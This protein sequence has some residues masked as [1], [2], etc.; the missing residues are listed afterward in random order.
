MGE[1]LSRRIL[2]EMLREEWRLHGHLFGG[3]R[4]LAF[5]F[6]VGLLVAGSVTLLALTGTGLDVVF[7]GLHVLAFLFG[8][9]TGSIG[10]VG[11]DALEDLLEDLTLLVFSARTLPL[12]PRR[13]LGIF[14]VKDV[15]YYAFL[16]LL[17]MSVGVVP[18]LEGPPVADA[19]TVLLLWATLTGMFVLG[20]ATTLAGAGLAGRGVPG[21]AALVV[22]AGAG[23]LAWWWGVDIAA[24]TFYGLFEDPSLARLGLASAVVVALAGL[25]VLAF[26]PGRRSRTR[27]AGPSFRLWRDRVDDPV[28][29]KTLLDLSRSSG[30][31]G[32]VLLSG[33]ILFA[34]TAALVDLARSITGV[35][36]SIAVS[37]GTVLGLAGFTTYN[38]LTR[39]DDVG[40][41]LIQPLDV[42]DVFQGKLRAF[43]LVGPPSV[44]VF[45]VLGLAWKGSPP[46]EA[47]VGAVL[48][49]G[50]SVHVLGVTAFLT[51]FAPN[52]F[53]FD[54]S[55]FAAFGVAVAVPLIP[56]LV[57]GFG[58]APLSGAQ[59]AALAAGGL[60]LVVLG[61]VLFRWATP[62]W[63]R[64]LR[65]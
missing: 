59:L 49:V 31:V 20:V 47:L 62:R 46:G 2:R 7:L 17:P 11:R 60:A 33:A 24:L 18:A 48:A 27:T 5:P 57:T 51:G 58:Y 45:Y 35:A 41:Y 53:L 32:K 15:V 21:V 13:L 44:L 52:E 12:S 16:F 34:V 63:E 64:K 56:I 3:R 36:P 25:G 9:H 55:L 8:L 38:W 65:A 10:L 39:F 40:T 50:V 1:A 42:D 26:R 29:A 28:A 30:G 19:G 6:L 61:G 43:L 4:F 54:T 22:L 23:V 14:V 37:Y